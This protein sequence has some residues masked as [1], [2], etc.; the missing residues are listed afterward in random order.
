MA[1]IRWWHLLIARV[2]PLTDFDT[3]RFL[4]ALAWY[5]EALRAAEGSGVIKTPTSLGVS[6]MNRDDLTAD[7]LL[8]RFYAIEQSGA[9]WLN[10][11]MLPASD[12]WLPYLRRWKV[13]CEACGVLACF[14]LSAPCGRVGAGSIA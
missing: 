1:R 4:N 13:G 9:D 12:V 14:E 11:F 6:M 2:C 7:G 8:A 10:L 5:T 3:G